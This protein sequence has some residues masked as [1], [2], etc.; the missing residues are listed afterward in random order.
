MIETIGLIL[1][2]LI[3]GVV[4]MGIYSAYSGSTTIL[5]L[6]GVGTGSGILGTVTTIFSDAWKFLVASF[7]G[8]LSWYGYILAGGLILCVVI[9]G[10]NAY[11]DMRKD[12]PIALVK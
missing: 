5:R 4:G 7:Y 1:I 3:V 10:Y 6:A 9:W 8:E 11:V 12:R 2:F